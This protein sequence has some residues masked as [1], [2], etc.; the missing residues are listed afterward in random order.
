[1]VGKS[2]KYGLYR[3]YGYKG[4]HLKQVAPKIKAG[5]LLG[6]KEDLDIAAGYVFGRIPASVDPGEL[7]MG[8]HVILVHLDKG[9]SV[10]EH[11][12][13]FDQL[14]MIVMG[15]LEVCVEGDCYLL[16]PGDSLYIPGGLKHYSKAVSEA[17][18]V[19]ARYRLRD[20]GRV[21]YIPWK[22]SV[23]L[24]GAILSHVEG[25]T[26]IPESSWVLSIID[27]RALME[28]IELGGVVVVGVGKANVEVYGRAILFYY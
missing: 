15:E 7:G 5:I 19:E 8:R 9:G 14:S 28:G 17:V 25:S 10:P 20:S 3:I 2:G 22:A 21:E 6:R 27:G 26:V 23:G 1:M 16:R 13:P 4:A 11:V 18:Q 24:E 12:H